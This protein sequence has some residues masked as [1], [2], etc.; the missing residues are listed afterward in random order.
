MRNSFISFIHLS[1][2]NYFF[3]L[4]SL[5]RLV[6]K[7]AKIGIYESLAI[8]I[9]DVSDF[10][11]NRVIFLCNVMYCTSV[12]E[13]IYIDFQV[14]VLKVGHEFALSLHWV[15]TEFALSLHVFAFYIINLCNVTKIVFYGKLLTYFFIICYAPLLRDRFI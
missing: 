4:V 6:F 14:I 3:I 7:V 13:G 1:N 12:T 2:F 5:V 15:C 8:W 10:F 11:C 9:F